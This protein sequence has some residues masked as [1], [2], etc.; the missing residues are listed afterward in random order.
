MNIVLN[1]T[2]VEVAEGLKLS[3]FIANN[4]TTS[5]NVAVAL[6]GTVVSKSNWDSTILKKNDNILIIKAFYGG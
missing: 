2:N 3:D 4:N 5:G 1:N 6:N